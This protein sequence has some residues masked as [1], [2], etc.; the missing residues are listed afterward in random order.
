[1]LDDLQRG[2]RT[3]EQLKADKGEVLVAAYG[4]SRNTAMKARKRALAEYGPV[5]VPNS[6]EL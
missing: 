4:G 5:R 1:M 2:V 3:P 6:D